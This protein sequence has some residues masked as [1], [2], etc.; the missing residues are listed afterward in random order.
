MNSTEKIVTS[1]MVDR[2]PA[3]HA[4]DALEASQGVS[5]SCS[6]LAARCPLSLK[7]LDFRWVHDIQ[8]SIWDVWTGICCFLARSN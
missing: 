3:V 2:P 6:R 1:Q 4:G 8:K 7:L 5:I